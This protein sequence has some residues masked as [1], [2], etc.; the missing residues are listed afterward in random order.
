MSETTDNKAVDVAALQRLTPREREVLVYL[1]KGFTNAEV[2]KL[3]GLKYCTVIDHVKAVYTKLDVNSR[4][5]AAVI[6]AKAGWL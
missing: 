6:A 2:A 1:G 5:E 4:V 3:L